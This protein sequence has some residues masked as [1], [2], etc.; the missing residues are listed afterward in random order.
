MDAVPVSVAYT[1]RPVRRRDVDAEVELPRL[2]VIRDARVAEEAANGMLGA[3]RLHGPG[4]RSTGLARR[5]ARERLRGVRAGRR[6][7]AAPAA[8]SGEETSSVQKTTAPAV[9]SAA[10]VRM[11]RRDVRRACGVVMPG[12][13]G[14]G[15]N[16]PAMAD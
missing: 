14:G 4:V 12:T 3:E 2:L 9:A 16:R 5:C 8:G 1:G 11:T 13:V 15:S 6:R 7:G 10:A